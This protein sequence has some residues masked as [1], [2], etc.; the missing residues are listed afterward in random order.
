MG[1]STY[2]CISEWYGVVNGIYLGIECVGKYT[3]VGID[4]R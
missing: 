3:V 4:Y 1:S 2:L